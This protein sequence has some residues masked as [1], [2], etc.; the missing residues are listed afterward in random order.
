MSAIVVWSAALSAVIAIAATMAIERWGGRIG[1]LLAT[2]PTT[3]V[4]ASLGILAESTSDPDFRLAMYAV[5]VGMFVDAL[6]LWTWRVVPGWL[7]AGRIHL[8]LGLMLTIALAVWAVCAGVGMAVLSQM[9]S[10]GVFAVTVALGI[11]IFGVFSCWAAPPAPSA[12]SG[13]GVPAL[14]GRGAL[15]AGAIG[16]AVWLASFGNPLLAG[17]ASV[18]PA[19]FLTTMVSL[20]LAQGESVPVGAVGPM[21]LGSTSV[22]VYALVAAWAMPALGA[23]PGAAVAWAA[24][25]LGA[26][27]PAAIWLRSRGGRVS[28]ED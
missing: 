20:W 8:R 3:I 14:L 13:V 17:M 7:P 11:A 25:V 9:P 19:I 2:L 10:R 24:A 18:F 4:P 26:S 6:F 1:G 5:P 22:A 21:I 28:R 12:T 15:A 16:F 23:M 27:T